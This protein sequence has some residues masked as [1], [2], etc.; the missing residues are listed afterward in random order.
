MRSLTKVWMA[1]RARPCVCS[2]SPGPAGGMGAAPSTS[3]SGSVPSRLLCPCS[4][5]KAAAASRALGCP[6]RLLLSDCEAVSHAHA[7][8]T[9]A[10]RRASST[11]ACRSSAR[12]RLVAPKRARSD[13]QMDSLQ[14]ERVAA[15]SEPGPS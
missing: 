3:R 1:S 2:G 13:C 14:P 8:L 7:S 5:S 12:W 4:P 10:P 6:L 11:T 9:S 15:A